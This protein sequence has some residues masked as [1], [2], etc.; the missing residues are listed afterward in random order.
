VITRR[1]FLQTSSAAATALSLSPTL[2]HSQQ[3]TPKPNLILILADDLGYGDLPCYGAKDTLTPHIDQLAATGIRFTD[4]YSCAPLCAP[5]R[6]GLLTGRYPQ[7][8]GFEFNSASPLPPG[9]GLPPT[10][11]ILSEDLKSAGYATSL[12]GKWHLGI[13]PN[14]HPTKRGFDE[15][16]GF[17]GG[18]HRYLFDGRKEI[19]NPIL[20]GNT[21]VDETEYLTDAFTREA[22]SFIDRNRNHPF[23]LYL[24]PN[25]VHVPLQKPPAKYFDRFPNIP[26][27]PRRIFAAI[28][29]ALDDQVGAV[30][31]K[32]RELHLL[33]NTLI[34]FM[35][36]NGGA[37]GPS[38]NA[39]LRGLKTELYDGGI[40]VPLILNHAAKTTPSVNST[41]VNILD[42]YPTFLQAA[43]AS[44]PANQPPLEGQSLPT[45]DHAPLFWRYG[46]E[47]A[48][49]SGQWKLVHPSDGPQSLFDLNADL[50]ETKDLS[51]SQPDRVRELTSLWKKWDEK[52]IPPR[53][54]G[55]NKDVGP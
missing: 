31:D 37:R 27:Q 40:R 50:S 36:D 23:F 52:N 29:A 22:L 8:F 25:A 19:I 7:R 32:L 48:I 38:K 41:P 9:W 34:I 45:A 51:Q 47:W 5:A 44:R 39:P 12:I 1:Q 6:A 3:Q 16:F 49:R 14:H 11:R 43:A 20:R 55:F 54:P 53:W 42:L 35:S 46:P 30:R 15:F 24:A 28:L 2:L 10:E 26:D 21:E 4:A 18:K 17:L 13:E 33:D